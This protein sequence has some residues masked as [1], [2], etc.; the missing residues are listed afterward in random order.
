VR[1]DNR[2]VA[3]QDENRFLLNNKKPFY[4]E[5]FVTEERPGTISHV[6][7]ISPAGN[8]K[9]ACV[10]YAGTREGARDVA[11]YFS[12]F[13]EEKATWT[14]PIILVD[15]GQCCR[16][17]KRYIK[18]VGN[19]LLF[20]DKEGRLWL[21]Y[22]SI[23][24]G[25]WSGSSLN[26]K[27]S[28][29][30]GYTWS[31]SRKMILSPFLNL[32]N[33][34]KNK[35]INFNDGSFII[36]VYHEF[37]KKFSQLVWVRPTDSD[38][39]KLEIRKIT[40]QKKAIQPSLLYNGGK[41]LSAFFRNMGPKGSSYILIAHSNDMGQS[42]SGL[43]DTHLPNPNSGF[44]MITLSDGSYLGVV[45]NSFTDRSNLSL[46]ISRDIGKTWKILKVLENTPNREYSYPSINRSGRGFYHITYTY[47]K[48]RIKH[49]VFNEA[50][51][52]QLEVQNY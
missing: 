27:I 25:G 5:G 12:I 19:P 8:N 33:N 6:S 13:D 15:R 21:F 37:I 35:G 49:I 18:K 20:S 46:V 9:M 34:V 16:E 41:N 3:A 42:W 39:V 7:S 2:T 38:G 10:W 40:H 51:I 43:S 24:F 47:E 23:T 29:D 52:K 1:W 26:Y 17:L 11:I 30:G 32:T 48:R 50:W 22:A 31:K 44:D 4:S 45:N 28:E 14:K 36:P